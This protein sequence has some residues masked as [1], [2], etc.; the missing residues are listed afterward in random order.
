[1]TVE[2]SDLLPDGWRHWMV[3]DSLWSEQLGKTSEETD[4]LAADR[5]RTLGLTRMV[6]RRNERPTARLDV[7]S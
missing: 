7:L 5:G 2:V 3:S 6:A 1:M 4:M